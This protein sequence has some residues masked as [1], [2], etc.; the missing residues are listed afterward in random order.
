M[1]TADDGDDTDQYGVTS[2]SMQYYY[3]HL[4]HLLICYTN[5]KMIYFGQKFAMQ[6]HCYQAFHVS[7]LVNMPECLLR[8]IEE[9]IDPL[10][11]YR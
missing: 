1:A 6:Q 2:G 7:A 8:L 10:Q 3:I 4:A 5:W 11:R 9:S